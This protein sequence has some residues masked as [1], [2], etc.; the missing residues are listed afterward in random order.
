MQAVFWMTV[1]LLCL[2]PGLSLAQR[3]RPCRSPLLYTGSLTVATQNE[4]LWAVGKYAYD[5]VNQ[6]V[7][8]G[9]IGHYNNKSF[10]FDTLFLFDEGVLYEINRHN[11]TCVKKA[12]QSDFHPMEVPKDAAFVS[13]VVLGSSSSPGQGLL[14]NNWWGDIPGTK[15]H[16]LVSFTEFGCF[17]VSALSQTKDFGWVSI[18]YY[19]NILGAEPSWFIPPPFCEDAT[20]VENEDGKVT[21]FFSVFH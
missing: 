6:R 15:G 1:G 13:Q 10:I 2:A 9:E 19:D 8:L 11:R 14:V 5:A 3:P 16:Y 20:L 21:D 12:L 4:K 18:S 17:P 7:H